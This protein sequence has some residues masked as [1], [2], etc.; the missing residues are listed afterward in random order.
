MEFLRPRTDFTLRPNGQ[1]PTLLGQYPIYP[2]YNQEVYIRAYLE[3]AS[4]YTIVHMMASK[5]GF[6]PRYLYQID[7]DK[8]ADETKKMRAAYRRRYRKI[9][10]SK[11]P[12][13]SAIKL[14]DLHTKAYQDDVVEGVPLTMLLAQPNP[15]QAQ[16]SYYAMIYT[17]KKLTGNAFVWL[18]RGP[19]D[20][21][22]GAD[23]YDLPILN[24]FVL[25]SQYMVIRVNRDI[26][27]GEILGYTFYDSGTPIYLAKEDV[28]HWKDPNPGYDSYNFT[29]LYGV[30]PLQ[31]GL[32]LLTNDYAQTDASVAMFQNGGARG[33]IYN[34]NFSNLNK[35]QQEQSDDAINT[36]INNKAMKSAVAYLAGKH[37]YLYV[38]QNAVDMDLINAQDDTFSRLCN[39]FGCNPIVFGSSE[40]TFNNVEQARKDLITSAILPDCASFRDEE[41][42]VLLQAFGYKQSD[43]CIDVD[44]T[45]LA[46]LSDDMDKLTTRVMSNWTITPNEKREELGFDPL[47]DPNMDLIYGPNNITLLDDLAMPPLDPSLNPDGSGINDNS[48]TGQAV[49][50]VPKGYTGNGHQK[51]LS[52]DEV[53][54]IWGKSSTK[55]KNGKPL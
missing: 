18:D 14:K 46:E 48:G 24:M 51:R 54:E 33:V 26:L 40:T 45:D 25:P 8:P 11:D 42:R 43:Y 55:N 20:E 23:R 27:F 52:L 13:L 1:S 2:Q 32:K 34:E 29:Q 37:G 15:Y 21:V 41:N 31:P 30:S 47:P 22:E 9:L 7:K 16:D 39:L 50:N 36:K 3:N 4:V 6:I 44:V 53:N 17:Y 38:G 19:Y 5:W 10:K 49:P 28:L 12:N 35:Q